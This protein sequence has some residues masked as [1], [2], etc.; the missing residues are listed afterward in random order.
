MQEDNTN[1]KFLSAI[2]Y[3]G[4]LFL[5]GHFAVEKNN[6]DLRFHKYQ[7]GVLCA[8]FSFLYL[9][10]LLICLL[11]FFSPAVQGIVAFILTVSIS[12]A[13]LLMIGFGISYA[14]KSQQRQLPFIGFYAVRL[15]EKMD[16]RRHGGNL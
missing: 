8:A 4:V 10:D 15:R 14:L 5:I 13:Y 3:I 7:G 2:S 16:N 11:F 12:I 9:T 6:P 1:I